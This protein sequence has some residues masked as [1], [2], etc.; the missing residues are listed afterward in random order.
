MIV[1]PKNIR[2][3]RIFADMGRQIQNNTCY[4]IP[5][6]KVHVGLTVWNNSILCVLLTYSVGVHWGVARVCPRLQRAL[7]APDCIHRACLSRAVTRMFVLTA[8]LY[9]LCLL[10]PLGY[11]GGE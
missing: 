1:V 11:V 4:R 9:A 2:H 3:M 5:A 6:S 8:L 7:A 10:L